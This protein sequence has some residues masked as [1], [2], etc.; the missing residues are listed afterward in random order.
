MGIKFDRD[1]DFGEQTE[2]AIRV[3]FGDP[4]DSRLVSIVR[5]QTWTAMVAAR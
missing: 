4:V 1:D 3:N 5:P 2:A